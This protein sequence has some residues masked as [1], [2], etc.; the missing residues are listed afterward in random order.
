MDRG[1]NA[2]LRRR[3][4]RRRVSLE[5]QRRSAEGAEGGATK[6]SRSA[7]ESVERF[8]GCAWSAGRERAS[9]RAG[10][11]R[12]RVVAYGEENQE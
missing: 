12:V 10:L 3:S 1:G 9:A 2:H 6:T 5:R 7:H 11:C 8:R 4:T